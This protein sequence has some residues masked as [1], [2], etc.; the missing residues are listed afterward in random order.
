VFK[1]ALFV[2]LAV[3]AAALP[4]RGSAE[5]DVDLLG[6]VQGEVVWVDFWASWCAP[7]R[8]SFPWMNR[9]HERY[10]ARGLQIIG[11]NVDKER[12]LA[13][14]F[15]SEVPAQFELRFDP[16]GDVAAGFGVQAMPSSFLLDA[17][18]NVIATHYGFRM[19]DM[20]EYEESIVKALDAAHAAD[21]GEKGGNR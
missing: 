14:D 20:D 19:E 2:S 17:S 1:T 3:L 13:D 7:C 18:G 12:E 4:Q 10:A 5:A 8:R 6:D 9:M 11:V 21:N 16:A 15:L